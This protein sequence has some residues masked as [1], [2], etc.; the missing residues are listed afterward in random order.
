M[1]TRTVRAVCWFGLVV[2]GCDRRASDSEP[3]P[4]VSAA[5]AA[6]ATTAA[7]SAATVTPAPA[8]ELC[9]VPCQR[10]SELGCKNASLCAARCAEM[11]NGQLC[12]EEMRSVLACITREPSSNWECDE[13]GLA[14]IREGY[15]EREQQGF[16]DCVQ[17]QLGAAP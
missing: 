6:A 3:A 11:A 16:L 10:G 1:W 15:C 4:A 8:Q 5:A 12:Q 14:A 2:S 17:R 9:R 13:E 7:P